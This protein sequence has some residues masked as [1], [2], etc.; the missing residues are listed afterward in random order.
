MK[1]FICIS[2]LL[3]TSDFNQ[4]RTLFLVSRVKN[5]YDEMT[6]RVTNQT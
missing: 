1:I 6:R 2:E 3:Y 4:E 5:V